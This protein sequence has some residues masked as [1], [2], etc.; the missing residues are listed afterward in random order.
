VRAR[1]YKCGTSGTVVSRGKS[2]EIFLFKAFAESF[3]G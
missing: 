3:R 2:S 1:V